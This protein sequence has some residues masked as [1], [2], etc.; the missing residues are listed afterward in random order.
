MAALQAAVAAEVA[1]DQS[2]IK[3]VTGIGD[4]IKKMAQQA[5]PGGSVPTDQLNA[6]AKQLTD[7]A[8][9]LTAALHANTPAE[10][11]SDLA[12]N[13]SAASH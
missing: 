6:F 3:F 7:S 5:G 2:A 1:A 4:Q 9:A 13:P 10:Q 11:H 12:S 8:N